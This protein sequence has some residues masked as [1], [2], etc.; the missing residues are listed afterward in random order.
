MCD[1][2]LV[3][4]VEI[5][6]LLITI[7]ACGGRF[8]GGRKGISECEIHQDRKS[9]NMKQNEENKQEEEENYEAK[10]ELINNQLTGVV[11]KTIKIG[12][13][14]VSQDDWKSKDKG[15]KH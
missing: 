6:I 7:L 1:D 10:K 5:T 9:A 12:P 15:L 2:D 3:D 14:N 11:E 8:W 13:W 4:V